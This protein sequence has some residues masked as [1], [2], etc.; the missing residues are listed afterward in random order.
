M[1]I[2]KGAIE[3]LASE[4]YITLQVPQ[5][6]IDTRL[7]PPPMPLETIPNDWIETLKSSQ[8]RRCC[9]NESG[10][11]FLTEKGWNAKKDDIKKA[12]INS[13]HPRG[14]WTDF[15]VHAT[16][17]FKNVAERNQKHLKSL[18]DKLKRFEAI[19]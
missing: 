19:L 13:Q 9:G 10:F 1:R 11:W 15:E 7:P 12:F 3:Q 5:Y 2:I 14:S 6:I 17:H 8:D 16:K 4:G 18:Q